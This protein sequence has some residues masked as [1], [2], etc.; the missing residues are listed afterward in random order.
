MKFDLGLDFD[1]RKALAKFCSSIYGTGEKEVQKI[2]Y[3]HV[4]FI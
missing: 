1:V 2:F 3:D 4:T